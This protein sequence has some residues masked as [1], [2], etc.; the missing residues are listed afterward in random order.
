M[1][2]DLI[3]LLLKTCVKNT[4]YKYYTTLHLYITILLH[5]Y[6]IVVLAMCPFIIFY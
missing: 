4:T 5:K 6:M 2:C 3:R 1:F